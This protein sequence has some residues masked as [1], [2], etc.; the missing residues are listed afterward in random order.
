[1]NST[2]PATPTDQSSVRVPTL[3]GLAFGLWRYLRFG[4]R[5]RKRALDTLSDH[6][7][8]D[9]GLDG[10]GYEQPTWERYIRR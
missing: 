10:P 2:G 4:P 3:P 6:L 8:A 1:M 9:V 5:P 7:L